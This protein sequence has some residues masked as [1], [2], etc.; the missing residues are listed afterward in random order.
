MDVFLVEMKLSLSYV[1]A[2][3]TFGI[4]W[5]ILDIVGWNDPVS[6]DISPRGHPNKHITTRGFDLL[7]IHIKWF[8]RVR[9]KR[10]NIQGL[11]LFELDSS[12][13]LH[14]HPNVRVKEK[15]ILSAVL[16]V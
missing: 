13:R 7:K 6:D 4:M 9:S 8:L 11:V 10:F 16:L 1:S 15:I 14:L 3:L 5:M 12:G 2:V